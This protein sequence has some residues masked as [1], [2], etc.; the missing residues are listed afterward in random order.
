M[1]IS[2]IQIRNYRSIKD[3]KIAL[4]DMTVLLGKNNEGKSNL[5]MAVNVAITTLQEY[6]NIRQRRIFFTRHSL[7]D[8]VYRWERDYPI[9]EQ[10][11]KKR[12][13]KTVF[14]LEFV[15]DDNEIAEFKK[16]IGNQLNGSL[17]IK[18]VFEKDNKA[19]ISVVKQG[20]GS[21]LLN[22]KSQ[23]V[24]R[25]IAEHIEYNYIPAVRTVDHTMEIINDQITS[26]LQEERDKKEYIDAL[27]V[28][29]GIER[30]ILSSLSGE[31]QTT[32]GEF[33]PEV[34][35]VTLSSEDLGMMIRRRQEYVFM[36][37]DGEK[38]NLKNK[39]DGVKS[40]VAMSLLKNKKTI[41]NTASV[42]AIEEPES[43]LHPSAIDALRKSILALS[44]KSQVVI[45][46]HNP[47]FVNRNAIESNVIVDNGNAVEAANIRQIREV[48]GVKLSDNLYGAKLLLYVEGITD[49]T[50]LNA[51]LRHKSKKI[52][53]ALKNNEL[54]IQ[55]MSGTDHVEMHLAT[56]KAMVA[57]FYVFLDND[58]AGKDAIGNAIRLGLLL[59]NEYMLTSYTDMNTNI[60]RESEM[61]DMLDVEVYRKEIESSY[62]VSMTNGKFKARNKKWSDRIKDVFN[63][64]GK[65]LDEGIMS[66]IKLKVAQQVAA[67]PSKALRPEG[68]V[69][70]NKLIGELEKR[71]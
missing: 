11:G 41:P 54:V 14:V 63:D 61:E 66:E 44:Q 57:D 40:L 27:N 62:G 48:L 7:R 35:N 2:T 46:T 32:L 8:E 50:V 34:N 1:K 30:K 3:A 69:F 31:I 55:P 22:E 45:T 18:I 49:R 51:L 64:E 39:G 26:R 12:D 47:Q 17:Q 42:I 59:P 29:T 37:D 13:K 20:K 25:Y 56:A 23:K 68:D 60:N 4:G 19:A 36:I 9:S 67:N 33:L 58:R 21:K 71:I 10:K 65:I 38:T 16:N 52:A 53:D 24:A 6:A 70:L 5:L 28:I 15:L 43:H